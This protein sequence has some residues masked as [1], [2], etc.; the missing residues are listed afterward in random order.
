MHVFCGKT[1]HRSKGASENQESPVCIA[2]GWKGE[3]PGEK[4]GNGFPP[5]LLYVRVSAFSASFP[6]SLENLRGIDSSSRSFALERFLRH[7]TKNNQK[8]NE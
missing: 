1:G 6:S 7:T 8:T 2:G 3:Q 5:P 4:T